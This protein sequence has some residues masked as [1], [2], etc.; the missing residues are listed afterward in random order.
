[1]QIRWSGV[2]LSETGLDA[3]TGAPRVKVSQKFFRPAEVDHL[4][5]DASLARKHLGWQPKTSFQ[6]LVTEMVLADIELLSQ[7]PNA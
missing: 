7:N 3:R 5:G 2:G 4:L 6:E 1:M